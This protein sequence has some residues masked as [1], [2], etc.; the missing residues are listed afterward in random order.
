MATSGKDT[1][2]V[3][4][5]VQAAVDTE[6]HLIVVHEV[7][8]VG[9]DRRQLAN[10]ASQACEE[11]GA[12]TLDAVADR[13]YYEGGEIKACADAGITVTL[14]KPQTSGAKAD[15]RFGKQDFVLDAA[16]GGGAELSGQGFRPRQPFS[17][18]CTIW[19]IRS[20]RP[21]ISAIA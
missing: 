6:H 20:A 8:T 17:M 4:Y 7:T 18:R 3:G 10:I 21:A 1:G 13:G 5:N 2:I 19:A 14:L 15:G 11:L 9:T 12:E 16:D